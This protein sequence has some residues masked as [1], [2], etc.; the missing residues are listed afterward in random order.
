MELTGP[1]P[2]PHDIPLPLPV[3]QVVAQA[4]IVLLFLAHILFVG[5]MVGGS[6]LTVVC[7]AIGLRR[8][9]FDGLA[10]TIAATVTVNKSLAVVLGV[11][12]LLA[13]NMLYT[14]Y[15][16]S[17][18]ALTGYAWISIVPLVTLAFLLTYAHKYSWEKW[19]AAKKAHIALGTCGALLFLFIPLIF[20]GNINLMLFP[21]RWTEVRGFF[22][23]LLLANVLPR[24]LHFVVACMLVTPLFL[25]GWLTRSGSPLETLVPGFTRPQLRR[26]LYLVTFWGVC[27]QV[28]AGL[29][30]LLT[31]PVHGL[32]HLMVAVILLGAACA[33]VAL[34]LLRREVWVTAPDVG[35]YFVPIVALLTVTALCMGYGR[36]LYREGAIGWH[37][38]QMAAKTEE[39]AW[40]SAA[41]QWRFATGAGAEDENLPPGERVFK[42]ACASCHAVERV[43]VG[44]SLT[45]IAGLY[46]D[47][48]G[49][50]VTWAKN[51]GKKRPEMP[52]MPAFRLPDE[53]L[54]AAAEHMLALGSGQEAPPPAPS[55][56]DADA[57]PATQP[58]PDDPAQPAEP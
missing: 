30:V 14:V 9:P 4:L 12:P 3:D 24:Y 20:L 32:S 11:G 17:A 47:N 37:R 2:I 23:T 27:V 58:P 28:G 53:K 45:E 22:S 39:F 6:V 33:L 57:A 16:Y 41:A 49:G 7:E 44:P 51:P 25:V 55:A 43:L 1:I 34:V 8:R 10:R 26:G 36:H 29:L 42:A 18:N 54:L 46:K 38:Q 52:K 31:L 48:P 50:I 5:F 13:I 35:R 15:F 19:A 56:P 21:E 40:A